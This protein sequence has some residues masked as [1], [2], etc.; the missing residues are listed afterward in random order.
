[1]YY[2]DDEVLYR[3]VVPAALGS[4]L[5]GIP[6]SR[7]FRSGVLRD[8]DPST[9][10]PNLP[11]SHA[12]KKSGEKKVDFRPKT[13]KLQAAKN[14][15]FLLQLCG[16]FHVSPSGLMSANVHPL[17]TSINASGNSARS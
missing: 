3:A 13:L 10:G 16:R 4:G 12:S 15:Q 6:R 8:Q 7:R 2:L 9:V 11:V 17:I 14:C 1:M 5:R